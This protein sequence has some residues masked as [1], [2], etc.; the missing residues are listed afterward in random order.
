MGYIY[1]YIYTPKQLI[2]GCKKDKNTTEEALMEKEKAEGLLRLRLNGALD[3]F[4]I[5]GLGVFI[6][7]AIGEIVILAEQYHQER[8][9]TEAPYK[10]P[11]LSRRDN[12]D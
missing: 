10:E 2:G 9:G 6:P 8:L 5:Y 7:G 11:H 12:E 1:I 4:D 3:P